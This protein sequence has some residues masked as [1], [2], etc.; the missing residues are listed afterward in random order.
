MGKSIGKPRENG[1]II[2]KPIGK[3]EIDGKTVGDL[4]SG[5]IKH[6][7]LENSL[8]IVG[9][10]GKS[11][12]NGGFSIAMFYHRKVSRYN[13]NEYVYIYIYINGDVYMI[14]LSMDRYFFS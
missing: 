1:T 9:F 6:G 4:P 12:I 10:M 5:V 14:K 7:W 8:L 2:G 13:I 11:P 3:W